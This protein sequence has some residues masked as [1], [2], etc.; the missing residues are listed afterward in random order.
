MASKLRI[1]HVARSLGVTAHYLRLLEQEKRIPE[2]SYDRAG[3]FYSEAD[4]ELLK[5]LGVGSKPRR[6]RPIEEVPGATS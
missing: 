2:A 5:S 1:G 4:I 6:L 3:R